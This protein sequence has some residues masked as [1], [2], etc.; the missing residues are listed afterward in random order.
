M[1]G[2]TGRERLGARCGDGRGRCG[3][4]PRAATSRRTARPSARRAEGRAGGS[5]GDRRGRR[6]RGGGL[7]RR[8]GAQ[9]LG[10]LDQPRDEGVGVQRRCAAVRRGRRGP[11]QA[12]VGRAQRVELGAARRP[13][14]VLGG[15]RAVARLLHRL[16]LATQP[17]LGGGRLLALLGQLRLH[18]R[19]PLGGGGQLALDTLAGGG[20]AGQLVAGRARGL[21]DLGDEPGDAGVALVA[22][23]DLRA[24]LVE[25]QAQAACGGHERRLAGGAGGE[26]LSGRG[27]LGLR[28]G[29]PALQRDDPRIALARRDGG[30]RPMVADHDLVARPSRRA[31]LARAPRPPPRDGRRRAALGGTGPRAPRYGR[32]RTPRSRS[33]DPASMDAFVV[34]FGLGFVVAA[35]AGAD[36]ALPRALHA[37]RAASAVGAAIG[38]GIAAVDALYA[39]AGAAGAAALLT[40]DAGPRRAR[41]GRGRGVLVLLGARTLVGALR[42]RLGGEV[43]RRRGHAAPRLPH[44]PGRHRLQPAD[45]RLLG[46]D[47]RRRQRRPAPPT[48]RRGPCSWSPGSAI[49]SLAWTTA[50]ASGTAVARRAVGARARPRGGRPR[51]PRAHRLRRRARLDEHAR[52]RLTAATA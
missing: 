2:R 6:G 16:E 32:R 45:D 29:E 18:R 39:T 41:A 35:A 3:G 17:R 25:L 27:G 15:Q 8:L 11:A 4:Q 43:D 44:R 14:H 23:G 42:V 24:Q 33:C 37:A 40:V 30:R 28:V 19:D 5:N 1:P 51:R 22:R 13:G 9:A 26:L 50:L 46:G 20:L 21:A 34:G 10:R 7:L 52:P 47:L 49:G 31:S 38:A 12:L 48:R 36:V